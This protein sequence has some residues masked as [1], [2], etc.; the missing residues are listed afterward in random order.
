MPRLFSFLPQIRTRRVYR[1]ALHPSTR[2]TYPATITIEATTEPLGS[3]MREDVTMHSSKS[4]LSL[5]FRIA[6]GASIWQDP[7]CRK[8]NT[9]ITVLHTRQVAIPGLAQQR[10]WYVEGCMP[11]PRGQGYIPFFGLS[12]Y[13]PWFRQHGTF[14]GCT[15]PLY[16]G[17]S[18][19]GQQAPYEQLFSFCG[20]LQQTFA[21][22]KEVHAFFQSAEYTIFKTIVLSLH[23]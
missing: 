17:V 5:C 18:D 15:S 22:K 1:S 9:T 12:N 16:M 19:V 20:T 23:Y 8:P 14:A 2:F 11:G 13:Q 7:I 4:N 21:S 10:I 6:R 3:G